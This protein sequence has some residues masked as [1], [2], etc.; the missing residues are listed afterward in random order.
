MKDLTAMPLQLH[1]SGHPINPDLFLVLEQTK[2][3]TN[4][5]RPKNDTEKL[6]RKLI[7]DVV[8]EVLVQ[9]L[10]LTSP[11][12]KTRK[13]SRIL[14]TGQRLLRQV[15]SEID[16]LENENLK[17]ENSEN[18][19]NL[20]SGEQVLKKS[21]EWQHFGSEMEEIVLEI[22]RSI[23]KELIDDVVCCELDAAVAALQTKN[24][25]RRKQLFTK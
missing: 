14:P 23:F 6:H 12:I 25:R 16:Q 4:I 18:D 22:E 19:D 2:S 13:L 20:V 21:V 8:N 1:S 24:Q 17:G 9:K 3:Q 5:L 10:E 7:F 11:Y 15:C